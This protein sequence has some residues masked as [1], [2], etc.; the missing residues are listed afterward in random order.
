[1]TPRVQDP[2][3]QASSHDTTPVR[4][5]NL[6][7]ELKNALRGV[8]TLRMPEPLIVGWNFDQKRLVATMKG[9]SARSAG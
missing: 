8:A 7:Y 4:M 3:C 5:A 1:M 2:L 6:G 9:R